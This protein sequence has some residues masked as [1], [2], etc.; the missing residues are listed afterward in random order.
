MYLH[1]FVPV[2]S[3]SQMGICVSVCMYQ[4]NILIVNF[5]PGFD[6]I[7]RKGRPSKWIVCPGLSVSIRVYKYMIICLCKTEL[8]FV[9]QCILMRTNEQMQ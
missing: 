7:E 8:K 6:Y 9:C 4:F 1:S 5:A 2:D 3:P